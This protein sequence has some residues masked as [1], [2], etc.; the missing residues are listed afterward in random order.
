MSD[1]RLKLTPA[2]QRYFVANETDGFRMTVLATDGNLIPNEVFAYRAEP[3]QPGQPVSQAF[4][5]HICSPV[6]LEEFPI[7]APLVDSDPPWFRIAS[8][9]LVFRSRAACDEVWGLIQ[10]DVSSLRT[11]MD[12]GDTLVTGAEVWIG[13]PPP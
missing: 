9:D 10:E 2:F 5:S 8:L 12:H 4:F 3:I 11:S 7:G 1:R 13:D 6:D